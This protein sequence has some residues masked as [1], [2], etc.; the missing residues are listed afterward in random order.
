MVSS[1]SEH[2]G[3]LG[4]QGPDSQGAL[5][6]YF[7][8]LAPF[9]YGNPSHLPVLW[10]AQNRVPTRLANVAN[11]AINDVGD[12]ADIH[13]RDKRTVGV[14]LANL[15][16]NRTYRMRSI[17]DQG[18]RFVRLTREG[19]SLR[20]LFDHARGLTTRDGEAVTHFKIAG[21][22]GDFVRAQVD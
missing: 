13:P 8:Q 4:G 1:S 9:R 15:A 20:I 6:F 2:P 19:Q 12:V 14:R 3:G 16:L 18:P 17:Q 5:P 10:E 21:L 22:A 11:V 7:V